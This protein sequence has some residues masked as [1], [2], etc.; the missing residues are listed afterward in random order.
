MQKGLTLTALLAQE[1]LGEWRHIL[2][3][4][5][6]IDIVLYYVEGSSS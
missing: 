6:Y 2:K 1:I 5:G 4:L 3:T